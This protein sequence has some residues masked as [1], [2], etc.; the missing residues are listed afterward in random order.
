M[1][2]ILRPPP[3]PL[4]LSEPRRVAGNDP[5]SPFQCDKLVALHRLTLWPSANRFTNTRVTQVSRSR[6][7][8]RLAIEFGQN[9]IL[10]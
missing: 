8:L 7:H 5:L 4:S 2:P 3:Q 1:K 9:N 10:C 6:R